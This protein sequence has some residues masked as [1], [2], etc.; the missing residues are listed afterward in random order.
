[1]CSES[2]FKNLAYFGYRSWKKR[3]GVNLV[4]RALGLLKPEYVKH[5]TEDQILKL[6]EYILLNI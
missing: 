5:L 4:R 1:M 3:I 2:H 6:E